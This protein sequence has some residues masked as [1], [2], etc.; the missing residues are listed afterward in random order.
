M[1]P[2][3]FVRNDPFETFG[4]APKVFADEGIPVA[5]LDAIDANASWP[6]LD[7]VDGLVMFGG[8][9]NVDRTDEHPFLLE[10]RR[11]T[12]EA[13]DGGVPFLGICLGGQLLARAMGKP[14]VRAPVRE[15][16]FEPLHP[17]RAAAE[18]PLLSH[19]DDGDPVFHWHEDTHDLPDGA[20]LLASGDHIATQAY[21]VGERAWG[22]QF[23]FEIDAAEIELWLR[24]AGP[25]IEATWGRSPAAV[26]AQA[27]D[28][29]AGHE[30]RGAEVFRRFCA[31]VRSTRPPSA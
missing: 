9:M 29:L 18:D 4:I 30:A 16:G 13:V 26:R 3:L 8:S 19:Y 15:L 21:R 28:A 27:A 12:A 31:V 20:E 7:D 25:D 6:T 10:D 17:L 11:I 5:T 23:H 2:V 14:V 24:E 1:K 22:V